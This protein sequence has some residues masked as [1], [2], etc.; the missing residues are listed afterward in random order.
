M[1]SL[2][3]TAKV[4]ILENGFCRDLL[5]FDGIL[6]KRHVNILVDGGS[7]G[8]FVSSNI[9]KSLKVKPH[10]VKNQ[11]LSFANGEQAPCNKEIQNVKL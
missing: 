4:N 7:M 3:I 1:E 2:G 5:Y 11:V 9:I 8:D 10:L 6:E